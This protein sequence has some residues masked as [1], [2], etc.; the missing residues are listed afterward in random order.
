MKEAFPVKPFPLLSDAPIQE[1]SID[2]RHI[3]RNGLKGLSS[4]EV[5]IRR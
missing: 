4:K 3:I 1:Q 2:A 5:F